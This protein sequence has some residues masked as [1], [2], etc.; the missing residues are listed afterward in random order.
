MRPQRY[1]A[2]SRRL[3]NPMPYPDY[4]VLSSLTAPT[5]C[6]FG[7]SRPTLARA[8]ST[9]ELSAVFQNLSEISYSKPRS[10]RGFSLGRGFDPAAV[11]CYFC[12]SLD[13]QHAVAQRVA[14]IQASVEQQ[15]DTAK[16]PRPIPQAFRATS[17]V[18]NR[19]KSKVR[20]QT[21]D[22]RPARGC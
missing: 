7:D 13:L 16:Y 6:G 2:I 8:I 10:S 21:N 20:G 22:N 3:M 1:R 9:H 5:V 4:M 19:V 11:P 15:Q 14:D 17:P 12:P 18:Y